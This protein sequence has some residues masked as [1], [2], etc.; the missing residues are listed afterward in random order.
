MELRFSV[1][2]SLVLEI[3][4]FI[5]DFS[6]IIIFFVIILV[7]VAH[8]IAH[9]CIISYHFFQ[10]AFQNICG[11]GCVFVFDGRA[12]LILIILRIQY[13]FVMSDLFEN[14]L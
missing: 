1:R 11:G 5:R 14:S 12:I 4:R 9:F 7:Y 6:F 2:I 10:F 8:K 3:S 13:S